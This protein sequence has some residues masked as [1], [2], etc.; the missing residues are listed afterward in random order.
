MAAFIIC[1]AL[2]VVFVILGISNM[3]GNISS[4]H[5]YHRQRVTEENKAAFGK[6]MG[7]GIIFCGAGVIS[8]GVLSIA[9]ELT[10]QPIFMTV[11]S[12][13]TAVGLAVGIGIFVY[14][15]MKYNKGVFV[16]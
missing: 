3:K 11:G 7:T 14:T 5:W 8:F 9:A 13:L 6:L 2:G 1:A 4:I 12:Y 16:I 10:A 15:T